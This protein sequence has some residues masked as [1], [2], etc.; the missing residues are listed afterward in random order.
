M[1]A[2]CQYETCELTLGDLIVAVTEAAFEATGDEEKAHEIA[3]RVLVRL[4]QIQA[5]S[6]GTVDRR[7]G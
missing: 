3:S 6:P 5:G 2:S 4:L 7:I 1:N